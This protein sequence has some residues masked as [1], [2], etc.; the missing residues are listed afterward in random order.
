MNNY[1]TFLFKHQLYYNIILIDIVKVNKYLTRT[2]N[3]FLKNFSN[4]LSYFITPSKYV[5][6]KSLVICVFY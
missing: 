4:F 5:V 3:F 2:S 6:I 1:F